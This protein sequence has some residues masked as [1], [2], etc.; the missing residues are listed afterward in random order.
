MGSWL[1]QRWKTIVGGTLGAAGGAVF[2]ITIGC[3]GG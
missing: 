2:A 1:K 3:K